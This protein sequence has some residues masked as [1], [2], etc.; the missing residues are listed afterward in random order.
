MRW[1]DSLWAKIVELNTKSFFWK[2]FFAWGP[3]LVL[4]FGIDWCVTSYFSAL[5][6]ETA[7][8]K[9]RAAMILVGVIALC[10]SLLLRSWAKKEERS[11]KNDED[12]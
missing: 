7:D 4:A 2:Q 10:L 5:D 6:P 12:D 9:R 3:P 8:E 1:F 11:T